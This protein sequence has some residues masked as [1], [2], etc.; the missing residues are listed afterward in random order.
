MVQ[1]VEFCKY[2]LKL[3]STRVGALLFAEFDTLHHFWWHLFTDQKILGRSNFVFCHFFDYVITYLVFQ[4]FPLDMC[5]FRHFFIFADVI[6][7]FF[8]IR[9]K[10]FCTCLYLMLIFDIVDTSS[11]ADYAAMNFA[12]IQRDILRVNTKS[13]HLKN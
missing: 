10:N 5:N 11:S 1:W 13:L 2:G 6:N 12:R 8:R 3:N 9:Q 4:I 7:I